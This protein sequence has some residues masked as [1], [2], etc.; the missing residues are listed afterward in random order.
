LHKLM[1]FRMPKAKSMVNIPGT[2]IISCMLKK[3]P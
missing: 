2:Q 1:K 3:H